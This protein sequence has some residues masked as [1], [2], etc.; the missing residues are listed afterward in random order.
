MALRRIFQTS[1]GLFFLLFSVLFSTACNPQVVSAG[2]QQVTISYDNGGAPTGINFTLTAYVGNTAVGSASGTLP[3]NG[4]RSN[5]TISLN[6]V[7]PDGTTIDI[8]DQSKAL[9]ISVKCRGNATTWF[10]PG[11]DRIDG[12]PGDR[13]AVYCALGEGKLIVWGVRPDSTGYLLASFQYRD[14][15]AAGPKGL[16]KSGGK[17]GGVISVSVDGKNNFWVAWN[18]QVDTPRG[19]FYAD[20]Q[21]DHGFAKGFNCMFTK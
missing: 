5:L 17:N 6:P 3:P 12:Q 10:T 20:G 18:G 9:I 13:L 8:K 19:S 2:C 7:Q 16:S 14:I 11:D 1:V 15:V 4:T 21:P